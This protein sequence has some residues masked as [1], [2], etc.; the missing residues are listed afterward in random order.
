MA[1]EEF[2]RRFL[3]ERPGGGR[4]HR[5]IIEGIKIAAGRQYIEAAPRGR[6]RWAR[7]NKFSIET[8]EQSH[9][10][11]SPQARRAGSTET[12]I[13]S[14]TKLV[15]R[16]AEAHAAEDDPATALTQRFASISRRS[17]V[18]PFVRHGSPDISTSC[19]WPGTVPGV[20]HC[21]TK[22]I[23]IAKP[24]VV[25]QSANERLVA[26]LR[27]ERAER[28]STPRRRSASFRPWGEDPK[29]RESVAD[30]RF[31]EVAKIGVEL[32]KIAVAHR[33]SARRRC[34]A[35]FPREIENLL[36]SATRRRRSRPEP[37]SIRRSAPRDPSAA[38]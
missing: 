10:S 29:M 37:D 16:P 8:V 22:R 18:S 27:R 20:G 11:G 24:Q 7:R 13:R 28:A 32:L 38:Q 5:A 21:A 9:I 25:R 12:A 4:R 3:A 34:R 17:T 36:R 1:G 31:L 23:E 15:S 30:L 26:A 35:G 6:A 2:L 19:V 33:P 14:S